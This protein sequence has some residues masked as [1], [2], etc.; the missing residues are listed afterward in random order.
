MITV[1]NDMT[2]E[3]DGFSVTSGNAIAWALSTAGPITSMAE[4]QAAIDAGLVFPGDD[5][6]TLTL[7][8]ADFDANGSYY[9]TPFTAGLL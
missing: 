8:L 9:A 2:L 5:D 6:S 4:L 3:A 7:T 1:G